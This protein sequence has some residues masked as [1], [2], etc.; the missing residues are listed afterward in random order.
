M[1]QRHR[2]PHLF[3]QPRFLLLPLLTLHHGSLAFSY[4]VLSRIF[5]RGSSGLPDQIV[6]RFQIPLQKGMPRIF[7]NLAAF[8][9]AITLCALSMLSP[10]AVL[11]S[12]VLT[13]MR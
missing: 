8:G 6:A 3:Q 12:A 7:A 13:R 9:W 5:E 11:G 2:P 4:A 1:M 10:I